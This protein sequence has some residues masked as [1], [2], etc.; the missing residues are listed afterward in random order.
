[1]ASAYPSCQVETEL[2]SIPELGV[3]DSLNFLLCALSSSWSCDKNYLHILRGCQ[4][5]LRGVPL[6]QF[7][8]VRQLI[9]RDMG[10]VWGLELSSA[11]AQAG[12]A[13]GSSHP[14]LSSISHRLWPRAASRG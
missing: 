1:M 10:R 9:H 14:S 6:P 3:C 13:V 11:P 12:G 5:S 8:V 4:L 7:L 2:L